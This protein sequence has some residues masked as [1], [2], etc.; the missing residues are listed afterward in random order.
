M[1]DRSPPAPVKLGTAPDRA[2][3]LFPRFGPQQNRGLH[4][5]AGRALARP[6]QTSKVYILLI[7]MLQNE[8]RLSRVR[9]TYMGIFQKYEH[10]PSFTLSLIAREP[11]VRF[12]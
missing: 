11:V 9:D 2:R 10:L 12:H 6:V 4:G 3:H 7:N 1:S 5:P 8:D